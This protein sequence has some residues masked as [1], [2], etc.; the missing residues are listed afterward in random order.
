VTEVVEQ[1]EALPAASV[2]VA[3]TVVVVLSVT[4]AEMVKLPPVAT[5]EASTALVQVELVYSL[6]VL[7]ASA[8]PVKDGELLLAGDTGDT[9][10][11]VGMP[12]AALSST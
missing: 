5:P 3:Y 4:L 8:V 11:T 9:L 2:A 12:G 6:T 7:L 1:D 10:E